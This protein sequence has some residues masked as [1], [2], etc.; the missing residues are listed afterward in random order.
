VIVLDEPTNG[1][2][3]EGIVWIRGLL[4]QFASEGRT[5]L[6]SSHLLREVEASVDDVVVIAH[7]QLRHASALSALRSRAKPAAYVESPRL[8]AVGAL[9]SDQGWTVSPDGDGLVVDGTTAAT[10]GSAA[11]AAGIELHQLV[12]RDSDLEAI[13]LELTR[14]EGGAR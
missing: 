1:L 13:F 3:P 4:R 12:S 6:I 10:L 14:S 11:H 2:D 9:A 7:G 8:D 5:V